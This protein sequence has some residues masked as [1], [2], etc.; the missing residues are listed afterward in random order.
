MLSTMNFHFFKIKWLYRY[1]PSFF[2]DNNCVVMKHKFTRCAKRELGIMP[3]AKYVLTH[4]IMTQWVKIV[5]I[6]NDSYTI[7]WYIW[8]QFIHIYQ[9]SKCCKLFQKHVHT[10]CQVSIPC[11][12]RCYIKLVRG[13]FISLGWFGGTVWAWGWKYARTLKFELLTL[14]H[15]TKKSHLRMCG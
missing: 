10:W 15:C 8:Y 6:N 9:I 4:T 3:P 12:S 13:N 2:H 11:N 5:W 14:Q 7:W 1:L